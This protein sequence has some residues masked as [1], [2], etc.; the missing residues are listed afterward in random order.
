MVR[1]AASAGSATTSRATRCSAGDSAG[2][3]PLIWTIRPASGI[4]EIFAVF[5]THETYF[6]APSC[7][8]YPQ[9]VV[10]PTA[11][12]TRAG[13]SPRLRRPNR[14]ALTSC[15]ADSIQWAVRRAV[16]AIGR[17][18]RPAST[19]RVVSRVMEAAIFG[20]W[21]PERQRPL[22]RPRPHVVLDQELLV[23]PGERGA[24]RG[25]RVA[26][27]GQEPRPRHRQTHAVV[28]AGEPGR[29]GQQQPLG[30]IVDVDE[31]HRLVRRPG[32][33]HLAAPAHPR[34]PVR[35]PVAAVL[36]PDD[37]PGPAEEH[38]VGTEPV[39]DRVL[40]WPPCTARTS[41]SARPAGCRSPAGPGRA[42]WR[43]RRAARAWR[44]R[45]RRCRSRR[46]SSGRPGPR[47]RTPRAGRGSA[48]A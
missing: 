4:A 12:A 29:A 45:G 6:H 19:E 38:P 3:R 2:R 7:V 47:A 35:E 8:N 10:K 25:E 1:R 23:D 27:L 41:P 36:R 48:G 20:Q 33:E 43:C 24:G 40:A 9:R 46:T 37:Q 22:P 17:A 32:R 28:R 30:Q 21:Q 44:R 34:H 5:A 39:A 42:A 14:L 18:G 16:S 15:G 31:L 11:R 13:R 26:H